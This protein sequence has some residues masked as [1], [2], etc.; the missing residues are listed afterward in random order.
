MCA[1][2]DKQLDQLFEKNGFRERRRIDSQRPRP[3]NA[4]KRL[5]PTYYEVLA[6][7][8]EPSGIRRERPEGSRP[9]AN[10]KHPAWRQRKK[11]VAHAI[12][13]CSATGA[14]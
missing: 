3:G 4:V 1:R 8:R 14:R 9:A 10:K 2:I 6:E 5:F 11:T 13:M 7:R 12:E